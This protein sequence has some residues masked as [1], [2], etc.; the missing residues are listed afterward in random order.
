M[1]DGHGMALEEI[2]TSQEMADE[3]LVMGLRLAEGISLNRYQ[4]FGATP[5][6]DNNMQF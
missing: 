4:Q 5:L 3:F 6:N 2:L 1:V